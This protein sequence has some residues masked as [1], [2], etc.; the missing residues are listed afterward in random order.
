MDRHI[1]HR[2]IDPITGLKV[3]KVETIIGDLGSGILDKNG[4][5]I[6]EG[7]V[8]KA[9]KIIGEEEFSSVVELGDGVFWLDTYALFD[10]DRASLEVVGHVDD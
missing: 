10:Y 1:R 8:V 3:T 5:E 6:Y 2:V 4:N 7:D 9:K